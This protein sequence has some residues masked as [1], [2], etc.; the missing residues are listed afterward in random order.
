MAGP[1]TR[2]EDGPLRSGSSR[3]TPPPFRW[4]RAGAACL[5][6]AAPA[7]VLAADATSPHVA[8]PVQAAGKCEFA[9]LR[10]GRA[11]VR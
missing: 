11:I 8:G 3:E 5:R 1:I 4:G 7:R 2:R 6:A 9:S 10:R